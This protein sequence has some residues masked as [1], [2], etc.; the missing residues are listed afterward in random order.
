MKSQFCHSKC[1]IKNYTKMRVSEIASHAFSSHG[2]IAPAGDCK[3]EQEH[4]EV[5][6]KTQKHER[7]ASAAETPWERACDLRGEAMDGSSW[8]RNVRFRL[9]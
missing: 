9:L 5:E 2:E 4:E 8:R 7:N 3:A 6:P 1:Y